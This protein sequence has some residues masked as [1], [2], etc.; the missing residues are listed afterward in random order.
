MGISTLS[1]SCR[2]IDKFGVIQNRLRTAA[3]TSAD[4]EA[5]HLLALSGA[6]QQN[7]RGGRFC[8][9]EQGGPEAALRRFCDWP[10]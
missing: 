1:G 5:L 10:P 3:M 9:R 6:K 4:H 7:I 2:D 8:H